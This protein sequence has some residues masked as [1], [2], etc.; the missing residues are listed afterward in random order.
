M[1][2]TPSSATLRLQNDINEGRPEGKVKDDAK[3]KR[4]SSF[5][6]INSFQ[7]IKNFA[8]DD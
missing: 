8:H 4:S 5:N 3:I 2:D 6:A 1:F 7:Q